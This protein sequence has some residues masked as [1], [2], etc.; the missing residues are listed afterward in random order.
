MTRS[1]ALLSVGPPG[2]PLPEVSPQWPHMLRRSRP[3]AP[4]GA[5][6][7]ASSLGSGRKNPNPTRELLPGHSTG[8]H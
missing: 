6:A 5:T 1:L 3:R 4:R 2:K 7:K 8:L